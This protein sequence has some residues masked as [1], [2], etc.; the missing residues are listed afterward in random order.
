[1]A[2]SNDA[3]MVAR[4]VAGD[5]TEAALYLLARE[6]GFDKAELSPRYP[7]VMSCPSTPN[8]SA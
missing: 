5:P 4:R 3:E 7:R 2:L 6:A 8:A 1:M